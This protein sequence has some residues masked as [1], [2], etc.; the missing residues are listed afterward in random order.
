MRSL[1]AAFTA[2]QAVAAQTLFT[3]LFVNDVNQG[4]GTCIRMPW[5]IQNATAP[6]T[7]LTSDDMACGTFNPQPS[8]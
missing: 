1:A 4:N 2:I 5:Y 3:T 8:T 7:D 6:V